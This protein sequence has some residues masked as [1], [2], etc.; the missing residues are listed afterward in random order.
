MQGQE[1]RKMKWHT[2]SNGINSINKLPLPVH[3]ESGDDIA[4]LWA[5][6]ADTGIS[7]QKDIVNWVFRM[8]SSFDSKYMMPALKI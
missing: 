7:T 3:E 2:L 5:H 6:G 8:V 1:I 4:R